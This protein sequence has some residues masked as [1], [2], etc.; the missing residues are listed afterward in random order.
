M[1][2]YCAIAITM[3]IC[4]TVLIIRIFVPIVSPHP[5]AFDNH[6]DECPDLKQAS[7]H[8]QSFR[9][10]ISKKYRNPPANDA[11]TNHSKRSHIR[12]GDFFIP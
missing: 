9:C 5:R 4:L 8:E 12:W 7:T 2:F 1:F 10:V 11:P 6:G 3:I